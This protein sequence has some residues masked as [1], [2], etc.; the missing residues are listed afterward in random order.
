ML[1]DLHDMPETYDALWVN[2]VSYGHSVIVAPTHCYNSGMS[3]YLKER[4]AIIECPNI[5]MS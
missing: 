5:R 3:K 1:E 4:R 2:L